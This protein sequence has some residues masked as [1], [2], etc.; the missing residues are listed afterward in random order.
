VLIVSRLGSHS[1]AIVEISS[2]SEYSG[3]RALSVGRSEYLNVVGLK[4]VPGVIP[5]IDIDVNV[6]D[7]E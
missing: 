4:Y 5:P 1:E 6:D 2:F 7:L 3:A